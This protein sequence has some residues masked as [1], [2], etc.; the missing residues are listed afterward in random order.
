M[1]KNEFL[2]KLTEYRKFLKVMEDKTKS[3]AYIKKHFGEFLD[4]SFEDEIIFDMLN[5]AEINESYWTTG[6]SCELVKIKN[7]LMEY[8]NIYV[9]LS[10]NVLG[11]SVLTNR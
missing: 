11:Q 9:R 5:A 3:Y 8:F 2:G 10:T 6:K 7:K 4:L 1:T